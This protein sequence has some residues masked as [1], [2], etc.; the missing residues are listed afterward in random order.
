MLNINFLIKPSEISKEGLCAIYCRFW[1]T[2]SLK[3]EKSTGI[4]ITPEQWNNDSQKII[5]PAKIT[6]IQQENI[7]LQNESLTALENKIRSIYNSLQYSGK[8]NISAKDIKVELE[9]K[10]KGKTLE[11]ALILYKNTFDGKSV[12]TKKIKRLTE[13]IEVFL[14]DIYQKQKISLSELRDETNFIEKFEHFV[15]KGN[16]KRDVAWSGAYMRKMF[17]YLKGCIEYAKKIGG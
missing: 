13:V 7:R 17:P 3:K 12:Q 2:G 16:N 1:V 9:G 8:E 5:V 14:L 10:H 6:K 4:S 11:D 15:Q